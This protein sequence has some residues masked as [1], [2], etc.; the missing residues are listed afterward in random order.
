LQTCRKLVLRSKETLRGGLPA[1]F[2][3]R[4]LDMTRTS[5]LKVLKQVRSR[6]R[7]AK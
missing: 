6:L 3:A 1:D 2:N 7:A 4:R 5:L